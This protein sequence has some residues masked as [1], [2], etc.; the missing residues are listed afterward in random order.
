VLS[1]RTSIVSAASVKARIAERYGTRHDVDGVA[2]TAFPV[3]G[4]LRVV[5]GEL[6]V[7]EVTSQRLRGLAGA[8]LDG[9]LDGARLRGLPVEQALAEVRELP[10]IGPFAADL[11]VVRGAG[12]PDVFPTAEQR[13]HAEMAVRYGLSDPTAGQLAALAE[14]WRPFRS[15]VAVLLRTAREQRTGEIAGRR[16]TAAAR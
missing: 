1:Q 4:R 11:V 8:A 10:G 14:R 6:P 13:L 15:W 3:P 2:C 16:R 5:A 7:P 9:R 12:A